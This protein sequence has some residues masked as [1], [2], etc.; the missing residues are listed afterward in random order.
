ML[1]NPPL[2]KADALIDDQR[3]WGTARFDVN[4]PATG[5]KLADVSNLGPAD[6]EAASKVTEPHV[7]DCQAVV[8]V[9]LPVGHIRCRDFGLH[10]PWTT[11]LI[12]LSLKFTRFFP[13]LRD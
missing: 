4:D 7:A 5:A 8:L 9:A 10:Y 11:A 2:L 13:R 1:N 6:A 3:V 12:Y